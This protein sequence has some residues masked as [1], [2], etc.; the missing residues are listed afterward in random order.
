MAAAMAELIEEMRAVED[1]LGGSDNAD[2]AGDPREPRRRHSA[3]WSRPP[4][5]FCRR[6]AAIPTRRSQPRSTT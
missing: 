3:R 6:S 4:N 1:R 5:G 2:F